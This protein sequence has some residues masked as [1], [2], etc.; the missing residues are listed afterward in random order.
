MMKKYPDDTELHRVTKQ[1]ITLNSRDNARTPMQW[2]KSAHG[3][4]S[5][6]T[7]WQREN[8]SYTSINA[9][10]QVGIKGSV[11]E[12]W[13]FV[14]RLRKQH[15]DIFIYG[16]FEMVDAENNEVF[17][18]LRVHERKKALV[19]ANFMKETVNWKIPSGLVLK[20]SLILISNYERLRLRDGLLELRPFEAFACFLE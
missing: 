12:H 16:D 20:E 15:V 7:P 4:F 11:F 14:L 17:A 3:G 13:A 5:E 8:E 10:A 18:Y 19:V 9:A 6:A 1:G 2:D